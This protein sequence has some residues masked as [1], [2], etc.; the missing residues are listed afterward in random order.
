MRTLTMAICAVFALAAAQGASAQQSPEAPSARTPSAEATT[1]SDAD[2][3]TFAMIYVDLLDTAAKFEDE[4]NSAQTQE[5]ANEVR[6]RLQTESIAKVRERGWT[7]EKLNSVT[8]AIN[9]DPALADKAAKLIE[10]KT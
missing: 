7:P 6:G 2:L 10:D 8:A 1:V 5:Q 4:L 9:K 3:E